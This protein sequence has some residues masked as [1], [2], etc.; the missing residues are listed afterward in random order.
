MKNDRKR[1]FIKINKDNLPKVKDK[2]PFIYLERG[3]LEI[4]DS[5]VKWIDSEGNLIRLPVA[6]LNTILLG[7]GTSVTHEA[8]KVLAAANCTV[9]WVGEDSMLFYAVGQSPTN[10]SRNLRLQMDLATNVKKRTEVAR[11]LFSYRFPDSDVQGK[12]LSQLMGMEGRRVKALYA[13]KAETYGVGWKGRSYV[14][15]KFEIGD[16][17]N[18][19]L[20][21]LNAALYGMMTSAIYSMGYS[22][23]IGFIHSGSPLPF[24]YDMSD[25]YKDDLCIDL[26]FKLTLEMAGEYNRHAVADAFRTR[27]I[28]DEIMGQVSKDIDYILRGSDGRRTGK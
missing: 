18:Q 12:N 17:T 10:D 9:S 3:R 7:P 15:G 13:E 24:V 26:A 23:R 16:V 11:R 19:M 6:T 1:L 22:P 28:Q 4:D 2:Y 14:P 27:V 5:S 20:T 25:L 8:V 21:S